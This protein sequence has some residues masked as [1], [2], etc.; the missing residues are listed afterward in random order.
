MLRLAANF[1][2]GDGDKDT[3]SSS[4]KALV[5]KASEGSL[6]SHLRVRI[7]MAEVQPLRCGA[8]SRELSEAAAVGQNRRVAGRQRPLRGLYSA[9]A[10]QSLCRR[11]DRRHRAARTHGRLYQR[12]PERQRSRKPPGQWRPGDSR[13][14]I[15]RSREAGNPNSDTGAAKKK[16]KD[17]EQEE[18]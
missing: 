12:L 14:S 1:L 3:D 10:Q 7:R 18:R 2:G 9:W 11:C 17:D 4:L 13:T 15:S 8:A 16:K 5:G 6:C